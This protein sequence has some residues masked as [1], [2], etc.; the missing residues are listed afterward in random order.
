M[1]EE[2]Q[3]KLLAIGLTPEVAAATVTNKKISEVIAAVLREA[4]APPCTP[5]VGKLL[6]MVATK[7][8]TMPPPRERG[9]LSPAGASPVH[10]Q[11]LDHWDCCCAW[12]SVDME[13]V[14]FG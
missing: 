2:L 12:V 3:A 6:Y 13:G 7:V 14:G 11:G 10:V 8:R 4:N 9:R 5:T 1:A